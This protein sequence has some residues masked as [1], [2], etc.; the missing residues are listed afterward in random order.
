MAVEARRP[1]VGNGMWV[2]SV[3]DPDGYQL[4]FESR[5]DAPEES[6]YEEDARS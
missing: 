4:Y 5:T 2:T 6:I 3:V 1:F